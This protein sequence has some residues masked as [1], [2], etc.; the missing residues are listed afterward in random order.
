MAKEDFNTAKDRLERARKEMLWVVNVLDDPDTHMQEYNLTRDEQE[1]L[2]LESQRKLAEIQMATAR[3]H[4]K[5]VHIQVR[6]KTVKRI[7]AIPPW[8]DAEDLIPSWPDRGDQ[9]EQ[10]QLAQQDAEDLIPSWPDR[11]DKPALRDE[12]A[13]Q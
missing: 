3:L 2:F 9:K 11:E 7:G 12:D 10:Q 5:E 4:A 1:E 13:T 6:N 8:Q